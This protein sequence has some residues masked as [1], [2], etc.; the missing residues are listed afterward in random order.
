MHVLVA[1]AAPALLPSAAVL[2]PRLGHLPVILILLCVLWL[3]LLRLALPR[4]GR[5][6]TMAA[7][8]LSS[9]MVLSW[10]PR[11]AARSWGLP[12]LTPG[13]HSHVILPMT[14]VQ[15]T[16]LISLLA[17]PLWVPLGLLARRRMRL[18]AQQLQ[19]G[20]SSPASLPPSGP[21]R[22]DVLAA[23]A[24]A[25]P[26][27]AAILST[28]GVAV[29]ARRIVVRHVRLS[30]PGLP[31]SLRGL[32][33]GQ[34]TDVHVAYDLTQL[35]QLEAGL[36]LLARQ[37]PDLVVATGDLCD[38]PRL[39][40]DV[41]SLIGQVPARLGHF[42]CLGNHELYLGLPLV[43]RTFDRSQVVLLEDRSEQVGDLTV[44]GLSYP[45]EGTPRISHRKVPGLLDRALRDRRDNTVTLLLSHHPHVFRHVAG[46]RVDLMLAGHTHG[47]QVG[48]GERSL[49]EPAYGYVRGWFTSPAPGDHAQ[50]FV[51]S[52]LGH[53][54][55]F[56]LNC[57]PE[58]VLIEL[59]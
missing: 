24:W 8:V 17:A 29:G 18:R 12:W 2:R 54:L 11:I 30:V 3:L 47:G 33:I 9:L 22:R 23:L 6:A 50:L 41:V 7:A 46:R 5:R 10:G 58:V 28:Y 25:G 39:L 35:A 19:G 4:F 51:S 55:P 59:V 57:P 37:Q 52:G 13:Y 1:L 53:W 27:A 34:L 14:V 42:A 43:R 38:S 44:A 15:M 16:I 56:R 32:R 26:G 48:L 45:H 40:P 49:L 20:A 21:S 36:D 31:P